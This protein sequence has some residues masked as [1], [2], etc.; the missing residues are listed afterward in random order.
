MFRTLRNDHINDIR[1]NKNKPIVQDVVKCTLILLDKPITKI[2][3]FSEVNKD[4]FFEKIEAY[5][6]EKRKLLLSEKRQ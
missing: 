1:K 5:D 6:V 3:I 4:E 2:A